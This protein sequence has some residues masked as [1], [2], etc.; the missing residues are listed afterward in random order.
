M[1]NTSAD[2]T[3]SAPRRRAR[4][5]STVLGV[6]LLS[7]GVGSATALFGFVDAVLPHS[8]P[9]AACETLSERSGGAPSFAMAQIPTGAEL[10]DRVSDVYQ[11]G[12]DNATDAI[13]SIPDMADGLVARAML[14]GLGVA[15][16]ALLLACTRL[17]SRLIATTS[18]AALAA[19]TTLGALALAMLSA[20]ELDLPSIGPRAIA[21]ALSISLLAV[22]F[23]GNT[24]ANATL[25]G[26]EWRVSGNTEKKS[27]TIERI[28]HGFNGFA[29]SVS[30]VVLSV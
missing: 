29:V 1:P 5:G 6:L 10:K 30:S 24:G 3:P 21:F 7:L 11:A 17:A 20:H 4:R 25:A 19:G 26:R 16:L 2:L 28:N 9:M 12:V 8:A 14:A 23:A 22:Y 18:T 13:D 15:A 27:R